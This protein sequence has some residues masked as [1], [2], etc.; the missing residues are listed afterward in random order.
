[1]SENLHDLRMAELSRFLDSF[2]LKHFR[3]H[4]Y[5]PRFVLIYSSVGSTTVSLEA[6]MEAI[7][8]EVVEFF[9]KQT[10]NVE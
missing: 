7:K 9:L 8:A 4:F 10:L 5:S 2:G 1:M 6:P 3:A